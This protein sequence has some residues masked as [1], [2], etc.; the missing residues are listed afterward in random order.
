M[1]LIDIIITHKSI[2]VNTF[3]AFLQFFLLFLF[4]LL[5]FCE[6]SVIIQLN[7]G[8]IVNVGKRIKERRKELGLSVDDVAY[9]L[10][11]DRSTVYRYESSDIEKLPT[12]VLE[13]LS[14]VLKTTPAYLM[15]WKNENEIDYD[16]YDLMPIRTRKFPML[17]DIAC[18]SPIIANQEYETFIEASDDI[19]ADFCLTAKGDSMINARIFDGDIVFIKKQPIVE[20]GEIAAV[21][22][23]DEV[24]L[25][26]VYRYKNRIELRAE[27]PLYQPLNYEGYQL[28][29]IEILGKALMFQSYVR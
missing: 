20:N 28:E 13:P 8:V 22:I 4:L 7:G 12:T 21:R 24:T 17:G 16:K 3:F 11:K 25:K 23:G 27:N 15:G 5:H 14:N 6:N 29:E 10:K 19:N 2:L 18:G 26:R 9:A 1:R